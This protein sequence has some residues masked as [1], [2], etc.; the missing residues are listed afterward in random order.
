MGHLLSE[1]ILANDYAMIRGV[2][3]FLILVIAMT[4]FILDLSYPLFDPRIRYETV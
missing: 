3:F 4:T 1:A 2:I